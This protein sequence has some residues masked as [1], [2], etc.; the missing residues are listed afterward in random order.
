[1]ILQALVATALASLVAASCSSKAETTPQVRKFLRMSRNTATDLKPAMARVPHLGVEIATE[2]GS[3]INSLIDLHQ[4][5]TDIS[6]ALADV[7][8][9]AYNGQLEE[10]PKPFSQL[11]GMAVTG[12]NT[13]HLF[14]GRGVKVE[15]L[16][17]LKGLRISLGAPGS[18][19]A[20][21]TPRMLQAHGIQPRDIHAVRTPNSELVDLLGRGQID[22][23]VS[24]F[25][26]PSN[27]VVA[28]MQAGA[29]LV[30]IEGPAIEELRTQYP[31]LK[32]TLIPAGTYPNQTKPIRTIGVDVVLVCRADLDEEVVYDL[33]DAYF[34]TRPAMTPPNLERAPATPIPL[35]A[36]AA[37]YYRQ[38]ELSR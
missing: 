38:R 34:A 35:H 7:A 23:A 24:A 20:L 36:G 30:D 28:A 25:T 33:L 14:A 8:Y 29:R 22:V 21:I 3:S 27:Q 12:L 10:I 18:S 31:Y 32:G 6:G 15:T 16:R 9:L 1:M 4:E 17:D 37:R 5:K 26:V 11:R 19:V 13:I 2:G